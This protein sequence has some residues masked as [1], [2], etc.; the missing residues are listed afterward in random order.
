[1]NNRKSILYVLLTVLGL[2]LVYNYMIAP[3][4]MRSN[5]GMGMG[6]HWRMYTSTNYF[7]DFRLIL[8]IAVVI[9][10]LLLLEFL[11][12]KTKSSKCNKCGKEIDNDR[13]KVCPVCGNAL[14]AKKG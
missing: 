14:K 2:I 12:P 4:F 8:F 13:W 10:G 7:V 9:A 3:L 5:S 6:M 1:M 11:M